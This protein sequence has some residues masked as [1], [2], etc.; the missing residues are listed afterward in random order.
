MENVVI[1]I[2]VFLFSN[3]E[4]VF[5]TNA[6]TINHGSIFLHLLLSM[7][8][9]NGKQITSVKNVIISFLTAPI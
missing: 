4:I 9:V 1:L 8:R 5:T 6:L 3:E 2:E 7:L